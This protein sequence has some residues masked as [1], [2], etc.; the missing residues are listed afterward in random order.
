MSS[1]AWHPGEH[2]PAGE[3][4]R[5]STQ[6]GLPVVVCNRTGAE[7]GIDFCGAQSVVTHRGE[8]RLTLTSPASTCSS[9]RSTRTDHELTF[10]ERDRIEI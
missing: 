3:W 6:T 4:E 1:A 2:G 7:P 9:S 10:H 8:R 5:C